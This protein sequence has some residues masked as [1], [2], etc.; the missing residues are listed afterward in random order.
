MKRN[1]EIQRGLVKSVQRGF[2]IVELLIVVVVIAI[3][4]AIT[5]VAYNGISNQARQSA[6]LAALDQYD[7]GIRLYKVENGSFPTAYD[8]AEY[9]AQSASYSATVTNAVD[10]IVSG[11]PPAQPINAEIAAALCL[12][13]SYPSSGM[14]RLNECAVTLEVI[15][16]N[17][18]NLPTIT[19][20]ISSMYSPQ[21]NST[22]SPKIFASAPQVNP[23]AFVQTYTMSNAPVGLT[24]TGSTSSI[25]KQA[26]VTRTVAYRGVEYFGNEQTPTAQLRYRTQGDQSCGR[27]TKL[28][29]THRE[30]SDQLNQAV[31][32]ANG[33]IEQDELDLLPLSVEFEHSG[34]DAWTVCTVVLR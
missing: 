16:F 26:T 34:S 27:G 28:L 17:E 33:T 6:N 29:M 2:T 18:A 10:L 22:L 7:K 3:L 32:T 25:L 13:G 4:A 31:A 15:D 8:I 11:Q 20:R 24:G 12:P 14:F 21:L 30:L 5:V 23:D 1:T 19:T 9:S